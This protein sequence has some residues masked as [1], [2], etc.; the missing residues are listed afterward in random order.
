MTKRLGWVGFLLPT[1]GACAICVMAGVTVADILLRSLF[2]Y[3]LQGTY[4]IVQ[5]SLVTAIYA[6]LGETFRRGANL[7]VD[8]ID[9]GAPRFSR[10]VLAPL[11]QV[12]SF[13]VVAILFV[14]AVQRGITIAGYGETTMDLKIATWWYWVPVI[15][16]FAWALVCIPLNV[17]SEFV[18]TGR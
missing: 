6:G 3:P 1:V 17:W 18:R 12:L 10:I 2:N 13:C 16:G 11:A 4:E 14:G 5:L 9:Y 15:V 7:M 8:L